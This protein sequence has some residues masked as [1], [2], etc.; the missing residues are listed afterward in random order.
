V[1][2]ACGVRRDHRI[3]T[4]P[5]AHTIDRRKELNHSPLRFDSGSFDFYG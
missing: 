3:E 5:L 4:V 1:P 2:L